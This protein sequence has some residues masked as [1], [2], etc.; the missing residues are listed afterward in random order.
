MNDKKTKKTNFLYVCENCDFYSNKKTDYKRHVETQKH[1][2]LHMSYKKT[3]F[4]CDCGKTYKFRQGLYS[5]RKK[6]LFFTEGKIKELE[7]ENVTLKSHLLEKINI[8]NDFLKRQME[9]KDKQIKELIPKVGTNKF[10]I[11][12]FLNEQCKNAVSLGDFV[13]NIEITAQALTLTKDAGL[14]I[15]ISNLIM[16]NMN[17]LALHERPIHCC[18][19]KREVLY[20]KNETWEKDTNKANTKQLINQLC[21]KQVQSIGMLVKNPEEYVDMVQQCSSVLNEKKIMKDICDIAYVKEPPELDG[22]NNFADE[23]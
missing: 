1:K 11:N 13:N 23:D 22:D 19:K 18:D 14:T 17:K 8:E 2:S 9:E 15:G 4:S 5:H 12:I 6:C 21:S 3:N 16:E 7:E 10:N 20:I